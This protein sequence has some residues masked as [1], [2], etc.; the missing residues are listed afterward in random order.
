MLRIKADSKIIIRIGA[1][2]LLLLPLTCHAIVNVEGMRKQ[3]SEPGLSGNMELA[4]TG[5]EGNSDKSNL[6]A[7]ARLQWQRNDSTTLVI[8]NRSYG[9]SNQVRD[10]NK[11]F[12][13]AR[14]IVA[15]TADRALEGFVQL[16]TNEFSRLDLRSL[17]GG[18]VRW[19]L[20]Q[21]PDSNATDKVLA[22]LGIGA[23]YSIET[24]AEQTG[25][26]DDG[27]ETLWRMN[28]YFALDYKI[29]AYTRF[30]STTYYQPAISDSAD[31]RALEQASLSVQIVDSLN[32]KVSLDIAHDSQPPQGVKRTDTSYKTGLVYEF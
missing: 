22:T 6:F 5:S 2:L 29:N 32:L 4:A 23:F 26:T 12:L 1:H 31:Y 9:E 10:T 17:A 28:S 19:A 18:G 15:N 8:A 24:L 20:L 14:H 3:H 21:G 7:A 25:L 11:S 13:H 27:T 16:E 30:V